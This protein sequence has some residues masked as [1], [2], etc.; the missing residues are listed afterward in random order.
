MEIL[1]VTP[2]NLE[3]LK[4][5]HYNLIANYNER[6]N[7]T[8]KL[9]FFVDVVSFMEY[10]TPSSNVVIIFYK[11][12][13][14]I[15]YPFRKAFSLFCLQPLIIFFI[16]THFR[17]KFLELSQ[18]Y[19]QLSTTL[20]TSKR[21]Y[22]DYYSWLTN[23]AN[24]C[25]KFTETLATWKSVW[26]F[27]G[28]IGGTI[29]V[30]LNAKNI[31]E[32]I[33]QINNQVPVSISSNTYGFVFR[34]VFYSTWFIVILLILS[35]FAKRKILFPKVDLI[36]FK[37]FEPPSPNIYHLE[38]NLFNL[39]NRKKKSEIP[40]DLFAVPSPFIVFLFFIV[41][42]AWLTVPKHQSTDALFWAGILL[43]MSPT[44]VLLIWLVY[45]S[46]KNRKWK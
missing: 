30:L 3:D 19:T 15:S 35:F 4:F 12:L 43:A 32:L 41:L 42:T 39:L 16:E 40:I 18:T 20:N 36:F 6:I 7:F 26:Q 29:L 23:T 9:P 22:Q 25:A 14:V 8:S 17:R 13:K 21:Y 31:F 44:I 1:N 33:M 27:I 34:T 28:K 2:P 24:D 37:E 5:A 46:W 38:D 10:P 11:F 45:D